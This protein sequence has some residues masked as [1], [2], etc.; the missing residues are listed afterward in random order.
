MTTLF[1]H[2][3]SYKQERP[4][5]PYIFILPWKNVRLLAITGKTGQN[6]AKDKNYDRL[7]TT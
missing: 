2:N 3:D 7:P 4:G 5:G 6:P 1:I